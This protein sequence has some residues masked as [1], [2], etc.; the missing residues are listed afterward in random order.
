MCLSVAHPCTEPFLVRGT[1]KL[2]RNDQVD[3]TPK[4]LRAY[5]YKITYKQESAY[6]L[7]CLVI[8]TRTEQER[9]VFLPPHQFV[10][11]ERWNRAEFAFFNFQL[12]VRVQLQ[13][14]LTN[15]NS[16]LNYITECFCIL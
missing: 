14:Q 5:C 3:L 11:A 4:Q 9:I 6:I 1:T 16:L 12:L 7:S 15:F 10:L 2:P 8:C 13:L